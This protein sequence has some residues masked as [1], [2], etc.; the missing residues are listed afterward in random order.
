M[1]TGASLGF[2]CV[3]AIMAF[4]VRGNTSW[5]NVHTAGWVIMV[6]GLIGLVLPRR[7]TSWLGRRLLVRRTIPTGRVQ[8][9]QVPP[10]VARNPGTSRIEAGLPA[11]PSL[12]DDDIDPIE[13]ASYRGTPSGTEVVEDLYE[14]P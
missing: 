2:I 1:K 9:I 3:G 6:I 11:R 13:D 12:L 10:Y 5:L 7:T 8:Q 4:A 14:Q